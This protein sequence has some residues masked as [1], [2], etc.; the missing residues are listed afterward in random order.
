MLRSFE[1][2]AFFTAL[3]LLII[4]VPQAIAGDFEDGMEAYRAKDY[5]KARILWLPLAQGGHTFA[6]N[7]V[8][9]MYKKGNG[10]PQD[11]KKAVKYFKQSSDQGFSLASYNLAAMYQ[12]GKG[13]KKNRKA[14]FKWMLKAAEKR[15]GKAQIKLG[16]WYKIGFGVKK[17]KVKAL[18]WFLIAENNSKGR[19]AELA[20]KEIKK[21]KTILSEAEIA[22]A[23]DAAESF[24]PA[25]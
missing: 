4:A 12:S 11:H 9:M 6:M 10:V 15:F 19:L 5:G 13:V 20:A 16:R 3:L 14:A 8:G 7:N 23:T 1:M 17:S 25:S 2:R 18:E 24:V 22:K 21:V